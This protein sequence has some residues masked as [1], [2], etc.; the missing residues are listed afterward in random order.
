MRDK[1]TGKGKGK[2]TNISLEEITNPYPEG[3]N[4][5]EPCAFHVE[6]HLETVPYPDNT[7]IDSLDK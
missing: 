6:Q 4:E 3:Q 2:E 1:L 7:R 5:I